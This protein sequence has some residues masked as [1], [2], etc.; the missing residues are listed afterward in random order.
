MFFFQ[1]IF[2]AMFRLPEPDHIFVFYGS[3]IIELCK[4]N[5]GT[6]P[7]CVSFH[8]FQF[9]NVEKK[10]E[11]YKKA[12]SEQL[13]GPFLEREHLQG[14]LYRNYKLQPLRFNQGYSLKPFSMSYKILP[15]KDVQQGI[16]NFITLYYYK[17]NKKPIYNFSFTD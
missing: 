14:S 3:L 8:F 1:I 6:M 10:H 2:G 7:S 15:W 12:L 11:S 9:L 16:K 13:F 5:Q 4:I 17:I